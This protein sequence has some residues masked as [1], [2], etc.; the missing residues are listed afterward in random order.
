MVNVRPQPEAVISSDAA[1]VPIP[2]FAVT[3]P[4]SPGALA[5]RLDLAENGLAAYGRGRSETD[6]QWHAQASM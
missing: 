4:I 2:P 6:V 3:R 1:D 5:E